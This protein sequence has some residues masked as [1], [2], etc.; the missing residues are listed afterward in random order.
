MT[1]INKAYGNFTT[2]G[3]NEVTKIDV[4]E[5]SFTIDEL[6][7]SKKVYDMLNRIA[8]SGGSYDD[9]IEVTYDHDRYRSQENPAY[10]FGFQIQLSS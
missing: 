8:V 10:I 2:N 7:L 9:W 4:S 3:I 6:N 1:N 5:G